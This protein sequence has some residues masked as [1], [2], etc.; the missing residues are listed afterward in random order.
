MRPAAVARRTASPS[1]GST[2]TN[3]SSSAT[4]WRW[5]GGTSAEGHHGDHLRGEV[6]ELDVGDLGATAQ[7]SERLIGRGA[8]GRHH[9]PLGLLDDGAGQRRP[10]PRPVTSRA[11]TVVRRTSVTSTTYPRTATT[12]PS[13]RS[14][15]PTVRRVRTTPRVSRMRC[16]RENARP[17]DRAGDEHLVRGPLLAVHVVEADELAAR[18]HLARLEPV[19]GVQTRLTTT[20]SGRGR[21]TGT[22]PRGPR[23]RRRRRGRS[24]ASAVAF[25]TSAGAFAMPSALSADLGRRRRRPGPAAAGVVRVAGCGGL[26]L[27]RWSAPA[28]RQV[29]GR[30][31]AGARLDGTPTGPG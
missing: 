27:M 15:S 9:D 7:E 3:R 2:S 24:A 25:A 23:S 11:A 16:C 1:C 29:R 26:R 5:S 31:G 8:A 13:S 17:S 19:D 28:F 18:D 4:G 21:R 30:R 6:A 12:S 22:W 14:P 10:L 20:R